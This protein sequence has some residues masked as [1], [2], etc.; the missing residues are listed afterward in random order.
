M[1]KATRVTLAL[2]LVIGAAIAIVSAQ[3]PTRPRQIAP[4]DP[5]GPSSMAGMADHA[6]SGLSSVNMMKH[7]VLTPVRAPTHADSAKARAV[8][9]E[10]KRAIAKY[11]DTAAAVADG[12]HMFLPGMKNQRLYHFSNYGN[13]FTSAFRF[14]PAKPTSILYKPGPDGRLRLVGAMYTMPRFVGTGRLD[15]RVPLSIAR[16]HQHVNWCLPK[17][18]EEARF[19]ERYA[20]GS[21]KFG[22]DSPIATK[23]ACTAV[24]GDFTPHLFGWMV[25]AN[26]F[27]SDD[28]GAIFGDM[29]D[30]PHDE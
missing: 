26:V 4:P 27:A 5:S 12:F 15:A 13:A 19:A 28:L 29:H 24:G 17:K 6:M 3:G 25:H 2:G 16:W 7:M 8:A 18:G 20:D 22:P 30:A 1:A 9:A 10:L 23:D 14:D 21:P 11:Q